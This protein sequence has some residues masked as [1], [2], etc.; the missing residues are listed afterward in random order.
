MA[1]VS[2]GSLPPKFPRG[3]VAGAG[4]FSIAIRGPI[5]LCFH[6]SRAEFHTSSRR[7]KESGAFISFRSQ[8]SSS[9]TSH[10]G[11][12]ILD[13]LIEI[14]VG[15]GCDKNRMDIYCKQSAYPGLRKFDACACFI[16]KLVK[17]CQ[18]GSSASWCKNTSYTCTFAFRRMHN[19]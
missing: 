15:P 11:F 1:A 17:A 19:G 6:N 7:E 13:T 14:H 18:A 4:I 3:G 16:K 12:C 5:T 2:E 10:L 9:F 8:R